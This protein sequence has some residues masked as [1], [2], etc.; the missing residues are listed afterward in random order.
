MFFS[1]LGIEEIKTVKNLTLLAVCL[2]VTADVGSAAPIPPDNEKYL[3]ETMENEFPKF[4][5]VGAVSPWGEVSPF[6]FKGRLM[7]MELLDEG[8]DMDVNA[9]IAAIIRDVETGRIVGETGEECFYHSVFV[10]GDRVYLTGV[11]RDLENKTHCGDTIL[12]YETTDLVHWKKRE[13]LRKPGWSYYNTTLT[14]GPDGYVL[15]IESS[16]LRYATRCFTMFF[17]TSKDLRKW[18]FL[19]NEK[20]FPKH[21]YC[22]GPF[23]TYC[24]GWYYLTLVSEMP[25]ERW[26]TYIHRTKDF[27]LWECGRYNP[28]MM[29][30]QRDRQ[31]SPNA[32]DIT[33]DFAKK[34]K[35]HFIC[36]ASD[37]EF[38]EFNGKTLLSYIIGDQRGFYYIAEAWYDGSVRE[39]LERQFH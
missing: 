26:C 4:R 24:N 18:T 16:D 32:R 31:V 20:A 5:K 10:E 37:L 2:L 29:W 35:T 28:F 6:V 1:G 27:D 33:S 3:F 22:G 30:D 21:R 17:A 7:R 23:L 15:A 39:L 14:K 12:I 34:I 19:P 13:L 11:K 25:C 8:R 36:N 38:C 9:H